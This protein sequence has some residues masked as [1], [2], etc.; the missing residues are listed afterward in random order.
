MLKAPAKLLAEYFWLQVSRHYTKAS[1]GIKSVLSQGNGKD[2]F[3]D[4]NWRN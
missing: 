1:K 2:K 4:N 3:I